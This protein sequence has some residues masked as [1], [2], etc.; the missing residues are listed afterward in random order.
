MENFIIRCDKSIEIY[1]ID[2]IKSLDSIGL[3]YDEKKE[4]NDKNIIYI[5]NPPSIDKTI[6]Y[7]N[8]EQFTVKKYFNQFINK[9]ND[10]R[11]NNIY[12][13]DYSYSNLEIIN[14][15]PQFKMN[16]DR[17][18]LFHLPY[19]YNPIEIDLLSELYKKTYKSYHVGLISVNSKRRMKIS[20]ALT[21]L[22]IKVNNINKFGIDREKE[23]A[24]CHI[25]VNIHFADDYQ[26]FEEI[27]C[28]RWWYAGVP[29]ISEFSINMSNLDIFPYIV[30]C[31]YHNIT[32]TVVDYFKNKSKYMNYYQNP[33]IIKSIALNR[34]NIVIK[35]LEELALKLCENK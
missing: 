2:F 30:W 11:C 5:Q 19:C 31:P 35:N 22:G 18:N 21:L 32:L 10:K 25:L 4:I 34:K 16:I 27:R 24:K 28:M 17:I 13:M 26:V 20:Y 29:I 1:M 23:M 9:L 6:I 14:K 33:E 15:L 3:I 12:F 7:C 8:T